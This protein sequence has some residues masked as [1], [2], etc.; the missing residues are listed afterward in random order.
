MN[1][2]FKTKYDVTTGQTKVVSELANNRQV[3]S[4]VEAAGSQP[5]CGVFFGGMLG[6]FKVLPLALVMASILSANNVAYG[7]WLAINDNNGTVGPEKSGASNGENNSVSN[8][9]LSKWDAI[10]EGSNDNTKNSVVI[11]AGNEIKGLGDGVVVIGV[12]A[13]GLQVGTTAVGRNARAMEGQATAFGNNTYA[14]GQSTAIGNDVYA[15]GKSAIAMGND[16]IATVYKDKLP[17]KTIEKIF[18]DTNKSTALGGGMQWEGVDQFTQ[19]YL[20]ASGGQDN[21]IYS[22]TYAKGDGAIAI[23]SRSIGYGQGSLAMGTLS[24]ALGKESTA[25]GVRAYVDLEADGG[26]AIGDQSRVFAKNSFA[27]GNEAESTSTGS[28]SF[29]SQSK[30]VGEGSIAIGQNVGSNAQL[31]SNADTE[32]SKIIMENIQTPRPEPNSENRYTY[33]NLDD[34]KFGNQNH[35]VTL[36]FAAKNPDGRKNPITTLIDKVIE[37]KEQQSTKITYA[38]EADE[39]IDTGKPI[40]KTKKEGD[41]AISLGYHLSNNGD[42]TIAIGTASIVRG[43]NSVVLGA[44][45]NVGKHARNTI[46]LGIGTNIYKEN[47]VAIGTGV[48]VAGAGVVAIGSGVGVTKDNTIAVGYG[49]HGLSSES[50]VLGNSASLKEHASKSI[51][52]GN[53]AKVE[54]AKKDEK[55]NA[56]SWPDDQDHRDGKKELEMYAIALGTNA[57]V[58]AESGIALGNQTEATMENSVALGYKSTTKYFYQND[59]KNTAT[60]IEDKQNKNEAIDLDPYVPEGS[61]YNFKTDRTAGI[62]SVGWKKG[63]EKNQE[64]G[65]R[66]IVGVAPGALDSDVATIGQLRALAY[67]KKEG[68]VTYYTKEGN[69]IIKL[70]KGDDG[71]F[72]KVNTKDG[73][74]YKDLSAVNNKNV[75]VGPKGAGEQTREETRNRK[76]YSLGDMGNKIKFA[77]ILDG[78]I[79]SGSDQA[80]TGNQLKNVGDILGITVNTN[81][82]K[83]DTPSF[84]RVQY[85]GSTEKQNHTTFKKAIEES[86]TA[87]NKGLV[88]QG[89]DKQ[90]KINLGST[91]KIKAGNTT[92]TDPRTRTNTVY[93]S[94]NIRTAYLPNQKELLI[95][96][97]E[98]PEFKSVTVSESVTAASPEGTLTTKKYVDDTLKNVSTNL[99]YLSVQGTDQGTDSNY[100]NDGAKASN[101]VAIGVSAKV[102]APTDKQNYIDNA[103]PNA[104]GGV[105]IGYNTQ[106]KAKNAIVIGTNVSVD[107]PNSFV[108]GSDNIVD[109][110]SKGTKNHLTNKYDA[111]GERDAV[112]VI[113]SGTTLKNSKS[114]IA[115]GAVN[116][117]HNTK[118]IAKDEKTKGN[119]IENAAWATVIGNKN[120]VYNG[121]DITALGNNIQ[122]NV[123]KDKFNTNTKVNSNL[124]I[125]G[126]GAI[127]ANAAGSVVIG[128]EAKALKELDGNITLHAYEDV[129]NTVVIGKGATVDSANS[130]AIGS[131]SKTSKNTTNNGYG[132][133]TDTVL[134]KSEHIWKPTAGEFAIGNINHQEEVKNGKQK[135]TENKPL[136]RRITGLAAGFNDTDAVN[137]AQLKKVVSG[138]ATLKYKANGNNEQSIDL[139]SKGLNFTN[140]TYTEATVGVNGV[141]TFDLNK[142]TADKINNALSKTEAKNTYAKKNELN[143]Y[144]KLDG[145]NIT[146]GNN[147]N[148]RGKLDVY[149]KNETDTAIN[150][151]KETVESGAGINVTPTDSTNGGKKFT[152]S[153]DNGIKT[154]IESIGTGKVEASDNKTVTGKAVH[155]AINTAKSELSTTIGQKLDT[156]TFNAATFGLVGND[157]Q[158]VTKKLNTTIKIEGS[159]RVESNKK[160]IYVSKNTAGDGLEIKLGETLTGITS[161]GKDDKAKISFGGDNAKNE[162]TYTV[163]D[164]TATATFKFSK[165]GIDLG[166]KK[167]TNVASGIG[168]IASATNGGTETNLD[169]VL[170]GS[171]EDTYKSNAANVEDLAKVANAI[172]KK[173]LE[174]EDDKGTKVKR[175]LG[176]SLKIVG[177]K[178]ASDASN[179]STTV[180]TAPDNITV[181]AKKST[182]VDSEPNDTLEIRLAKDLKGIASIEN[183][184]DKSKIELKDDGI[185][186]T[187]NK[188]KTVKVKDNALEGVNKITA[189]SSGTDQNTNSIDL[190]NR[191]GNKNVVITAD[192]KQLTIAKDDNN[193]NIKLSNVSKLENDINNGISFNTGTGDNT[194][195][196]LK[197]GGS[198]LTFTKENNGIKLSGLSDGTI[199]DN[200][201]DVITG[202]QLYD[203]GKNHLGLTVD[204]GNTK[205]TAPTFTKLKNEDGQSE[206]K[207]ATTFVEAINKNAAKINEGLKFGI[208]TATN[209]STPNSNEIT[210]QLGAKL[211]FAGDDYITPSIVGGDTIKYTVN[212]ATSIDNSSSTTTN[213]SKKLVT[214]DAVKNYVTNK[215][216]S[217]STT[218][219]LEADNTGTDPN[220]IQGKV[221]LKDKALSIKGDT[222]I[223]TAVKKDDNE[224]TISLKENLSGISSIGK[225]D[226]AKI[227]FSSDNSKNEIA[228]T[229][230]DNSTYKFGK[231][232]LDLG[233]K[234]ITNLGSG[235]NGIVGTSAGNNKLD[236]L[237]KLK[238]QQNGV[239]PTNNQDK[240]NRAVNVEDLLDIAQGLVDKG[241]TFQGDE[242]EAITRKLGDTLKIVGETVAN[243]GSTTTTIT[244][245]PGNISVK[246]KDTDTLEIGLSKDLTGIESVGKDTDNKLEF[247]KDTSG[248]NDTAELKVGG[249][250]LTFNKDGEK[251]KISGLG[252]GQIGEN[253]SDTITGKQL[254]DLAT[255]LGINVHDTDKTKFKAPTFDKLTLKNVDGNNAN[256]PT[257]I[258]GAL[259]NVVS[260]LNEGLSYKADIEDNNSPM[261][262]HK[263]QYLGSKLD[264]VKATSDIT[265][266]S[267][268]YVGTNLITKYTNTNGN[269]KL[270]IGLKEKPAFKEISISDNGKTYATLGGNATDGGSLILKNK[271]G[272]AESITIK[273][274]DTPSIAFKTDGADANK[275]GTGVITGLADL[276]EKSDNTS[277]VNKK[278]VDDLLNKSNNKVDDIDANRPFVFLDENKKEVVKGRDGK[279]YKKDELKDATYDPVQKRYM[280]N[281]TEVPYLTEEQVKKVYIAARST[282][283]DN[284][285]M[286]IGNV[287]SGL[288]PEKVGANLITAEEAR[289]LILGDNNNNNIGLNKLNDAS[290]LNRVATIGDLQALSLAGIGFKGS[291]SEEAKY[292]SLGNVINIYAN[293]EKSKELTE[294]YKNEIKADNTLADNTKKSEAFTKAFGKNIVTTVNPYSNSEILIGTVENPEFT[295]IKVKSK[296]NPNVETTIKPDGT[297][298]LT[299]DGDNIQTTTT[300]K[301]GLTITHLDT[302]NPTSPIKKLA[303]YGVDNLT[304]TNGKNTAKLTVDDTSSSLVLG[305]KD[306]NKVAELKA[307]NSRGILNLKHKDKE[308]IQIEA[309]SDTEA[310]SIKIKDKDGAKDS[311]TITGG[312]GQKA[313]TIAFAKDGTDSKGT[314]KITGLADISP[315]ET[316]GSVAANKN[317]VDEKF[318]EAN[319]G[320][321]FEYY[322]KDDDA[323]K[324]VRG[325]DGKLYKEDELKEFTYD[326]V[327]QKYKPKDSTQQKEPT[328]VSEKDVVVK[329]MPKS[330]PI[331]IGNVA[332][333]LGL[334]DD[335]QSLSQEQQTQKSKELVKNLV[336]NKLDTDANKVANVKDLKALAISGINFSGDDNNNNSV[337]KNLGETL[338]IK[339]KGINDITKFNGTENN[340]AVKV[341]D[342]KDGLE[343]SLN[344]SL[345]GMKLF[346]TKADDD[347]NKSILDVSGLTVGD[348]NKQNAK[349][350]KDGITLNNKEGKAAVTI[351]SETPSIEFAKDSNNKGTGTISGLKDG[352][353]DKNSTEAVNGKQL[354]EATGAKL[355]DDPNGPSKKKMVFADGKDGLSGFE[356]TLDDKESMGAKGLTGKDGL[357]GKNANDKA[358]ALRDGEAGTV[359]FT[360]STGNR[361]VKT[362]ND[363]KYYKAT[364]V[365]ADGS[366]K[367]TDGQDAPKPVDT[368]QLS[369]VN[370]EGEATKPVVLGNVASGLDIDSDKAKENAE[371]VKTARKAVKTQADAVTT[372]VDEM[373]KKRQDADS[374]KTAKDARQSVIDVLS[375]LPETTAAEKAEKEKRLKIEKDKLANIERELT[376]ANDAVTQL[377]QEIKTAQNELN[378]KKTA[379]QDALKG[380]TVHQLLSGDSSI[381]VKR[382]ANLQDLKALGQAGLNFE[383]N[384][385]LVHKKL[386]D[387]LAIK[388]EGTFNSDR[389]ATGNI[390]V[391]MARDGK[392]LE[393]KLSDQLKNMTSFETRDINGKKSVLNNGGLTVTG[394]GDHAG[395][396][397]SYT[398][399]SVEI[400]D[401]KGRVQLNTTALSFAVTQDPSGR[402]TGVIRGLKDLDAQAT[403]DMA[404]N[405]NYVDARNHELRTQ[406]QSNDRN[407]RAGVAQAVAQANLP[408]NILPGKSTLSLATGNYMGS[409]A[410]AVGYSRVSDNGKLSVKFSLGHGDK[411][412]SVGAGVGYSW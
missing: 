380:D 93:K 192:G 381:D 392:G 342:K 285:A 17:Q 289:K 203:L 77:H 74:P 207:A 122:V 198:D 14:N 39:V 327:E 127:A 181:V 36:G 232:G 212:V 257:N 25:V 336:E 72:Y 308:S 52:I 56:M 323:A 164:T 129:N 61:S 28:L 132:I 137:V 350:S 226:K 348:T 255:Q 185:Y 309:A 140:G 264:I 310:G 410:F 324:V 138:A 170:K 238:G 281:N 247:K 15:V 162:I 242:G 304:M 330:Q 321:P 172:I 343:I 344:E 150:K 378:E 356:K 222:N 2:I 251:V 234:V 297:V 90:G 48:N 391:E 29:G 9:V 38:Y 92:V 394:S 65:L 284:K 372:K 119:H 46:A 363:G 358:N 359:V 73:T 125:L 160:N 278:Y 110:N 301:D 218:L 156:S 7:A 246:K 63:N 295:E 199:G 361:L 236:E 32:F 195:A 254:N 210:R 386:G 244:T 179:S 55:I 143:S 215:F 47:S 51:V 369:L 377:Q 399:D 403:G 133:A 387:T 78:E 111:K 141:V 16:D 305:D 11:G 194:T 13:K 49:A 404:A 94:D 193:R 400:T 260:K 282:S 293:S 241:L 37:E 86:I 21:R 360:D 326:K 101:S 91:L 27:I 276:D 213:N 217:Y 169:K 353:L 292:V 176:E 24:F 174:F 180:A 71:K 76:K 250:T 200:S 397:A 313:P 271:D 4:R 365:N 115:I 136:T 346:E 53:G 116:M 395:Q 227:S 384:D 229:A 109:Q 298:I 211:N 349:Y 337:H 204:S 97:K 112:V 325:R 405:K 107:I 272:N 31:I 388:G 102:E 253:S 103:Q 216:S 131:Y 248:A 60:L 390:K 269:G 98:S 317:Y 80:I 43:S 130:V 239:Q 316:D 44:L 40:Y 224:V 347:G 407:M 166:S 67:V 280:K 256:N 154:K 120:R 206:D 82:T 291:S 302:K 357:N 5:K 398:L 70:T 249:K 20:S 221:D 165:D 237:L 351:K 155:D 62:V 83:F 41:H 190:A 45:N 157:S 153:L 22:P 385:G 328:P 208:A 338:E 163:G 10:K 33:G 329:V 205:F 383:G 124:V 171:P 299:K 84:T 409:Q 306:N 88:I 54:N 389:T 1:K 196:T 332:S 161:V 89:D 318:A 270:E 139:T 340:I 228:F 177:E 300:N 274:G 147:S 159:E 134:D 34:L 187:T 367:K 406:M 30:A 311:I 364:D 81:N 197:V 128:N 290:K 258:V 286:S 144:I 319:A 273:A 117:E 35:I 173:G 252:D 99:H 279:L 59:N 370:H 233:S 66:R 152:V 175:N 123:S 183:E 23:G 288:N 95:G 339:G 42:N 167:I 168:E 362:N 266:N 146:A 50:I 158:A 259:E 64:L 6:A 188:D 335:T 230:G 220:K 85:E 79:T 268:T 366:V 287:A 312:N 401:K 219:T 12:G 267:E 106:S 412:T 263:T 245:A 315:T 26:V 105:A 18:R 243:T 231:D 100:K 58:T 345:T 149:S 191:D 148:L 341:N 331:S 145:S 3:A 303:T 121:T 235:L 402:G 396:S 19:K 209:A 382:A 283:P 214:E 108:L 96:I 223:T 373:L 69:K 354:V 189:V 225:D 202:N 376:A 374:L 375:M 275:K 113:G 334:D 178:T 294:K 57:A 307:D 87:I 118:H 126:N 261:S 296:D 186:L 201:K 262:K 277:A 352:S 75:F 355:I 142:N 314:G 68:V 182:T 408:I 135:T 393:V 240:L 114:S 322:K 104:E 320:Q 379:Y 265:N 371:K 411:K 333:G 151:A 184:K 8:V 368:P